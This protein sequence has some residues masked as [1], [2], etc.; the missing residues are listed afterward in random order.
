M[1]PVR[2]PASATL[3]LPR[4]A[5]F[6]LCL[7]YILPGLVGREPWKNDDAASFGVM[8]TMAHGSWQDWLWPNIAG[9]LSW[10]GGSAPFYLSQLASLYAGNKVMD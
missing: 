8:W 9:L 10:K 2:L 3:A 7:L 4:W 5:L 1:K 6:A